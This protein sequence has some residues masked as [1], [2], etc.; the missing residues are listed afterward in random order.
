MRG[1]LNKVRSKNK[2]EV[3]YYLKKIYHA[4]TGE[5]S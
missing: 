4:D 2:S 1:A 5:E 3:T